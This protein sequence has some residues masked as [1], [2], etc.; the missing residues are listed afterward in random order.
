M[1]GELCGSVSNHLNRRR[2]LGWW[3][4]HKQPTLTSSSSGIVFIALAFGVEF[5]QRA[6]YKRPHSRRQH[7]R[8]L[9]GVILP[10]H[11][12]LS[13]PVPSQCTHAPTNSSSAAAAPSS[14]NRQWW[15]MPAAQSMG[16]PSSRR[17]GSSASLS[18]F[19]PAQCGHDTGGRRRAGVA[20]G[21][22]GGPS[23]SHLRSHGPPPT[24]MRRAVG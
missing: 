21:C 11:Y 22:P 14:P 10:S 18:A 16:L 20:T 13:R 19:S 2:P 8:D 1:V 17:R 4:N 6:L 3:R 9:A 23:G 24:I 12:S 7:L 5:V 15:R